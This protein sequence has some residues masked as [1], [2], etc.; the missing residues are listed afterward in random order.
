MTALLQSVLSSD[1]ADLCRIMEVV[2]SGLLLPDGPGIRDPCERETVDVF[3][4]LTVQMKEDITKQAQTDIRNI[5]YRKIHVLLGMD[6][7][8]TN[9]QKNIISMK[10]KEETTTESGDKSAEIK[11]ETKQEV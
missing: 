1:C 4:H 7:L 11:Q 5:H 10:S 3:D 6:R 9:Y 8:L 2:A